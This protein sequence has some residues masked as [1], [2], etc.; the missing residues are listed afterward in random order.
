MNF[1]EKY[2]D[3]KNYTVEHTTDFTIDYIDYIICLCKP[4]SEQGK[5]NCNNYSAKTLY[6]LFEAGRFVHGFLVV[7]HSGNVVLTL[8]IDDF[9]GWA[10]GTRYLT[11]M[12]T[13]T[14]AIPLVT[15][16]AYP[17][18]RNLLQDKVIGF[19]STHNISTRSII[20]IAKRFE[21]HTEHNLYG[22]AAKEIR[23]MR[24][25]E[26]PVYYRGVVQTAYTWWGPNLVPPFER[27]TL[28]LTP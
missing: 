14:P 12:P 17:Y 7:K 20:S 28:P 4:Y 2:A 27:A 9:N 24:Q 5:I 3:L 19:C 11:H 6:R 18:L 15:G 10:I 8:G 16:V 25:I 26:Y 13:A 23:Q 1:F 22:V 21:K